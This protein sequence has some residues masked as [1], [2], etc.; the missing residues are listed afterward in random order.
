MN[1]NFNKLILFTSLFVSLYTPSKSQSRNDST[2]TVSD[3]LF[4]KHPF[5]ADGQ[6]NDIILLNNGDKIVGNIKSLDKSKLK[7]STS[8][9]TANF[10]IA[11]PEI[12]SLYSSDFFI[13][14]LRDGKKITGYLSIEEGK[15]KIVSADSLSTIQTDYMEIVYLNSITQGFWD[16]MSVSI[17]GGYTHSKAGNND[18]LTIRGTA[19]YNS[20]KYNPDLYFNFVSNAL[21]ANDSIRI[22]K[23]RQNYGGNFRMYFA[24]SWFGITGADYLTSD[25]LQLKLRSTY[26]LGLGYYPIRTHTMYLNVS[27]GTAINYEIL[28]E[29]AE[30]E[31]NTSTEG[32]LTAEYNAF[33][34]N[35]VNIVSSLNYYPSLSQAGRHRVNG[36]ID[37]KFNLP[38]DFYIGLGYTVNYDSKPSN[39]EISGYDYVFQTTLGWSL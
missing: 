33:G 35:N 32:F 8:Y 36:K 39:T 19:S 5:S 28:D 20:I 21:D 30:S 13:I 23:R 15:A 7:F 6:E 31:E 27:T 34:L 26:T 25:E 3:R 11:W 22:R 9:S 37:I 2:N 16:S 38:L 17:D 29:E 12:T 24:K 18:Q 1:M 14:N 4:N 10:S